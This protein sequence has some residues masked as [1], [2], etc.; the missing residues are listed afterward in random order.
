[1]R[2]LLTGGTGLLG[3]ALCRHWLARG[4]QLSVLS[5]RPNEV[6]AL[7]G[8][9]VVALPS[10][11]HWRPSLAFDVL[12]NLAGAPIIDRP[13]TEARKRELQ[14]SRIGVTEQLLAALARAERKPGLLLGASAIGYY[15]DCGELAVDE[16]APAGNDF[17]ARLCVDWE[18]A[19][20]RA[21]ASGLRV[22]QLRT[23]L[24]LSAHGGLL[25]RMDPTFRLGLGA[26]L[27]SGR[28]WM[29]FIHIDDWVAAVDFLLVEA[30]KAT[31][32]FN[33]TAPVPV[34]NSEFTRQLAESLGR[35][36]RLVAPAAL[37][38]L[39]LGARADLLLGGQQVLPMRLQEL[40]FRFRYAEL[41]AALAAIRG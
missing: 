13:W 30:A 32:A 41:G 22:C 29:S 3:R 14:D 21:G 8:Q 9:G 11:D 12:V 19:A 15:G 31:G 20:S 35:R 39:V 40:G 18:A 25:A 5:R 24:V 2:I 26:R 23:G 37:L 10:L 38:R 17:A 7:C 28:Q 27:G 4:H 16:N 36:A 33:L 34:R 6:P 1:M